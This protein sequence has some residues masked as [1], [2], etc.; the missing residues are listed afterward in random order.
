MW[1]L[2]R[3]A[4]FEIRSKERVRRMQVPW[5][6]LLVLEA[7]SPADARSLVLRGWWLGL[8][9][10]IGVVSCLSV[11]LAFVFASSIIALTSKFDST[12]TIL[13]SAYW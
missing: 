3:W 9:F 4:K 2:L 5:C 10:S 12:Q 11:C 6:R 8:I 1:K 13:T 7:L